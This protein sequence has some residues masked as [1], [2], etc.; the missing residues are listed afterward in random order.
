MPLVAVAQGTVHYKVDGEGPG[1]VL[2][3]G[4]GGDADRTFGNF[5]HHFADHT[6]VRPNLSGS[7]LTTDNGGDLTLELLAEQVVAAAQDAADP[8]VDLL[9]FS[10]GAVV[11][12]VVTATRPDLV[13]RLILVDGF[14]HTTG[15][16]D[17]FNFALWRELLAID[18]GLFK[19][20]VL[21]QGFS[22]ALLDVLGHEGLAAAV[23]EEWPPGLARQ[24]AVS[25]EMDIRALLGKIQAPTLVIG[26]TGDQAAP[27][28]ASRQLHAG[29]AG[30]RLVEIEGGG[31][32]DWFAHPDQVVRLT[33]EFITNQE[34]R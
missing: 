25:A 27:I 11:A 9:G 32:L 12:S 1:L 19:R 26:H 5:F 24:V 21:L 22:S 23:A 16:R 33:R 17:A 28:E 34:A 10:L 8:P 20:L 7:G 13:R 4:V 15:P 2:V 29:I 31:H 6:V 3:H 18:L 14:A 30:S